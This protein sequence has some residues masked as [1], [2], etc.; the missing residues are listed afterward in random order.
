VCAL[1]LC[2]SDI[3]GATGV[4]IGSIIQNLVGMGVGVGIAFFASW[5]LSLLTLCF[6]PLVAAAGSV[7]MLQLGGTNKEL[8]NLYEA[9]G[10]ITAESIENIRTVAS[11][12]LEKHFQSLFEKSLVPPYRTTIKQAHFIGL[13]MGLGEAVIFF[14]YAAVFYYGSYLM[15]ND[16]LSFN[17]VMKVFSAIIFAAMTIGQSM[18]MLPDYGKACQSAANLFA[19]IYSTPAIDAYSNKGQKDFEVNGEL[20][21]QNVK[22]NYPSRPT[23]KVLQ[24]LSFKVNKGQTIAL[25]GQSGCG[26]STTVQLTQRFYE[27]AGGMIMLDGHDIN[28]VNVAYLRQQMGLVSQEPVLFDKTIADN[29]KYGDLTREVSLEEVKAA[30]VSANISTFVESMPDG[31]ETMVGEKGSKLSGGQ[32]QRVAIARALIRN[33]KLLLLDEATSALDTESEKVVQDALDRARQGRTCIVIAHRLST[34]HN[35][36]LICVV[37]EGFIVEK[38]THTQLMAAKGIYYNLNQNTDTRDTDC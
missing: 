3:S 35:A 22:F 19:L 24:G 2:L 16:D 38:G 7:Q 5:K 30:A 32:K 25:V 14:T 21:F 26:K 33:P 12:G 31:Y 18:S 6:I 34:I 11:L 13:S 17:D 9:S 20:E 23:Q 8:A 36:D 28:N 27:I 37:Q 4:R 29:I 10:K 15:K 1:V